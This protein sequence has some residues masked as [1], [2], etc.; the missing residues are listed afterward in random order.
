M[1]SYVKRWPLDLSRVAS[2]IWSFELSVSVRMF[3]IPLQGGLGGARTTDKGLM[4]EEFGKPT[5][6]FHDSGHRV[7]NLDN[8]FFEAKGLSTGIS[9]IGLDKSL[10]HVVS[11]WVKDKVTGLGPREES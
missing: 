8:G 3:I 11:D 7:L 4:Q 2:S 9:H 10:W 1:P 5:Y 6:Q